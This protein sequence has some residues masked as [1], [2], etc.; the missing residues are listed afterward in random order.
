MQLSH[1]HLHRLHSFKWARPR[2]VLLPS[3][4][5]LLVLMLQPDLQLCPL[6]PLVLKTPLWLKH[7]LE[8]HCSLVLQLHLRQDRPL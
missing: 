6:G 5:R 8:L 3:S 1:L 7:S 2:R 4:I